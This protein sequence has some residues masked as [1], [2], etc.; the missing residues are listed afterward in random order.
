MRKLTV[1]L[2]L[3][4]A[5]SIA[6]QEKPQPASQASPPAAPAPKVVNPSV[7]K[8]KA[9]AGTQPVDP[10]AGKT[11][12]EIVARVN[13]EIIT[14]TEYE[15]ARQSAGDDAKQECQKRCTPEQLQT[16]IE[17]RQKNAL[18]ELIDQSLLVQRGKDMGVS[19]EADVIKQ[20]DQIRIQ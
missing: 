10:N 11:V 15:K 3:C 12:E 6:A 7:Q 20:L 19:V 9:S 1:V 18:R 5:L 2:F 16:N 13:N 14:L 4:A 17:E 8:P